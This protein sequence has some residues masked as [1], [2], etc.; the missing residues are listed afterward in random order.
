MLCKIAHDLDRRLQD[1][2]PLERRL[3]EQ[4]VYSLTEDLPP[5]PDFS[6]FHAA[7]SADPDQSTPDGDIR[8]AYFL[9]YDDRNCEYMPLESGEIGKPGG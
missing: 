4:Q 7:F 2:G 8:S 3:I 1:S 5:L 6:R 9:A